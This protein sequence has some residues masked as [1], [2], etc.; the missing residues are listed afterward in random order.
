MANTTYVPETL[1]LDAQIAALAVA[2]TLAFP[3][4]RIVR[5]KPR[6]YVLH[7][8]NNRERA[9][10]GTVEEITE[11]ARHFLTTGALPKANGG[12]W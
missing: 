10:W 7:A 6:E 11:D 3:A 2:D 8:D 5:V 4:G 9:R 12:R 1:S